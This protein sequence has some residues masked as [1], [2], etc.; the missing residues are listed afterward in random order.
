MS[1]IDR[2]LNMKMMMVG[3]DAGVI[4]DGASGAF[5]G[6]Q[7]A[8]PPTSA[9]SGH[10]G[11]HSYE[12]PGRAKSLQFVSALTCVSTDTCDWLQHL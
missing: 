6:G 4:Q 8:A 5:A 12:R 3:Q 2:E 9:S 11:L 10:S 1:V 7:A